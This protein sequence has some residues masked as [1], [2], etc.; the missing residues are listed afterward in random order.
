MKNNIKYLINEL[1]SKRVDKLTRKRINTFTRQ[2]VNSSTRLLV[3]LL[4]CLL[5]NF[6]CGDYLD[7][8]PELSLDDKTVFTIFSNAERFHNDVY[9]N[10]YARFNAVGDY[11]PVP[12]SSASDES[13]SPAGYHGTQNFN[14]GIYDGI[15]ADLGNY[16]GG[17]RKANIFLSNREIIPF[18]SE[19]KKNQMLGETYFLRAFYF[20][21]IVKRFGGM[22]IMDETRIIMPG[23]QMN[24]PRNTYKECIEFIL[25]DLEKAVPLLP[26]EL[27]EN[28]YG[29]ATRGA[30]MALKARV[31]LYAASPLW[32]QEMGE[33]LWRQAAEAAKALIDLTNNGEK[34]Y[35]LYATGNAAA[36]YEQLFFRRRENGNKEI[37]FYKHASPAGFSSSEIQVWAPKGGN[38]GGDGAVCPTQNFVDLFEMANGKPIH[39]EG[40][41]Y[42][43]Q[44]P[45]ANRDPRFYK[46]I[47]YNGCQWQGETLDLSY[48]PNQ[49]LSGAHRKTKEYTR[50]GYYVRK[51]LPESVK[52]QTTNTSYHNWIYFRLAEMYLNYAEALNE[53]LASPSQEVYDAVNA[54]RSRSGAVNL[55]S[56]LG[57]DQMRERIWNERAI[58]LSFEEHRWWDARRW[59]KATDWFGGSMYEMEITKENGQPVYATKPFYTRTY[60]SHMD[61]YPIPVAEMRKNPLYVQNPGWE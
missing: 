50:T 29:R 3:Y 15:D 12:M 14:M 38:L 44:N 35:E 33:D 46:T 5:V 7:R 13:D 36:D 2:L 59:K 39:E 58:E 47:L 42:N 9:T 49:D 37:I 23:E 27:P 6:S 60:R 16:Y 61:L 11:Q 26:V 22:P 19:T 54:V 45:Y 21:E 40:S 41:G 17:I 25:A 53:T 18:P 55:P 10:L 43:P 4:T 56:G 57:K 30:A 51:Y 8:A 48:N 24:Y 34:V 52:Y 1:T 28:E 20:N 32:R 31:L